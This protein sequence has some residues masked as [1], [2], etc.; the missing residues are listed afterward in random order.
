MALMYLRRTVLGGNGDGSGVGGSWCQ[1]KATQSRCQLPT[2]L[3]PNTV[4][5]AKEALQN[6]LSCGHNGIVLLT[7]NSTRYLFLLHNIVLHSYTIGASAE[8]GVEM[9]LNTKGPIKLQEK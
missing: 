1:G 3:P 4:R 5:Q 8:I 7:L 2:H 9:L 6:V